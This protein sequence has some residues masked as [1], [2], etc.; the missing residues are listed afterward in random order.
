MKK[1]KDIVPDFYSDFR[2]IAGAC[3]DTC[4]SGWDIEVDDNSREFYQNA[5]GIFG[6][7][8]RKSMTEDEDGEMI[9][10]LENGKCPFLNQEK[11]CDIQIRFGEE[12][13]C[14]TCRTFPRLSQDYTEFTEYM[15]SAAC[16]EACRLILCDESNF[17]CIG[18]FEIKNETNGYPRELMNFLLKARKIT[19]DHFKDQNEKFSEQ[20]KKCLAFSEYVQQLLDNDIFSSDE[21]FNF[22][23][24]PPESDRKKRNF[25]FE[26][27]RQLDIADKEWLDIL[28]QSADHI[29]KD[30]DETDREFRR[31]ALYYIYRYYLN[32]V[33]S[34]DIITTVKRIVC[35]YIVCSGI[36]EYLNAGNDFEKRVLIYQK[37]SK[38]IEHSFENKSF[39]TDEFEINPEFSSLSLISIL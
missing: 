5:E 18:D 13:I 9:F 16:P 3:P 14:E 24:I 15:L 32:A 39:L 29:L 30:S 35:C 8:L 26:M 1:T 20:L 23:F 28:M 21:L 19:S 27:H 12:H 4:C 33:D 31:L 25:V 2:C 37:Y 36:C 34:Y 17:E 11:L 10:V 7:K 38:E 6:E 22:Q